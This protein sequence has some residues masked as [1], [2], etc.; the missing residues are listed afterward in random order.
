[1][2]NKLSQT[3][4]HKQ[5]FFNI[6]IPTHRPEFLN[7]S[8]NTILNQSIKP[9]RIIIIADI[10][11]KNGINEYVE[12]IRQSY[13][14]FPKII[15]IQSH[16]SGALNAFKQCFKQMEVFFNPKFNNYFQI[17]EDDAT[18]LTKNTFKF[19]KK[20]ID[21]KN[22][23]FLY[24]NL[25]DK[26]NDNFLTE[27]NISFNISK[28]NPEDHSIILDT[29]GMIFNFN[30]YNKH[31]IQLF[32]KIIK[33]L[34]YTLIADMFALKF[35]TH[36]LEF[37]IIERSCIQS[38]IHPNQISAD[39]NIQP[40]ENSIQ[41]MHVFKKY[42]IKDK[43]I[44]HDVYHQIIIRM[45]A[46]VKHIQNM[47]HMQHDKVIVS[48]DEHKSEKP[49]FKCLRDFYRLL[50]IDNPFRFRDTIEFIKKYP[51]E[52]LYIRNL[53]N[54]VDKKSIEV[55]PYLMEKL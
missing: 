9:D 41:W 13:S 52:I 43:F 28:Y 54:L 23:E 33:D 25:I 31:K 36:N 7:K 39:L 29:C 26:Q 42:G 6:I 16:L 49:S 10:I 19:I 34:D 4:D 50:L 47:Q 32:N 44:K 18:F 55:N 1:M 27:P 5:N 11:L 21:K 37:D 48:L 24:V 12:K 45:L 30:E 20:H 3:I 8:L 40:F 35:F 46:T 15:I 14:K 17:L 51:N 2:D 22:P 53:S 38:I